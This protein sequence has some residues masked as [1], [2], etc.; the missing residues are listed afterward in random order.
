MLSSALPRPL[1][2]V[3][4]VRG[5]GCTSPT[6]SLDAPHTVH[7]E[8]DACSAATA[9]APMSSSPRVS[10]R[11]LL[12]WSSDVTLSFRVVLL[13]TH[14]EILFAHRGQHEVENVHLPATLAVEMPALFE[15]EVEYGERAR[16]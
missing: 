7:L 4:A 1:N 2:C 16:P 15:E 13:D 5:H 6:A 14:G 10:L 12:T 9:S 11:L 8:G 3:R